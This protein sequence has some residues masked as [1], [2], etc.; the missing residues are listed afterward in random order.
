MTKST[1]RDVGA[2]LEELNGFDDWR[3]LTMGAQWLYTSMLL[4]PHPAAGGGSAWFPARQACLAAD[5]DRATIVEF[6][7]ELEAAGWL[8]Y[9]D[10]GEVAFAII[11]REPTALYRYWD[12]QHVLLYVGISNDPGRRDLQHNAKPWKPSATRREVE[13]FG[14]RDEAAFAEATAIRVERPKFNIIMAVK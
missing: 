13:W 11:K 2:I 9:S 4:R 14:T 8:A 1:G 3:A 10:D 12:A 7:A 6:A 5:Q